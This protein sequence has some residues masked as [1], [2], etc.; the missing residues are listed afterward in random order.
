MYNV[1]E[2]ITNDAL[3]CWKDVGVHCTCRLMAGWNYIMFCRRG[4]RAEQCRVP[5]E[6][7]STWPSLHQHMHSVQRTHNAR[8]SDEVFIELMSSWRCRG[9]P[10]LMHCGLYGGQ[11]WVER[12]RKKNCRWSVVLMFPWQ[13][14]GRDGLPE[15]TLTQTLP[16]PVHTATFNNPPLLCPR[17]HFL[18][19]TKVRLAPRHP[20][21]DFI[22]LSV[23]NHLHSWLFLLSS[24]SYP[25]P[26][27]NI[28]IAYSLS[29]TLP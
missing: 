26:A 1:Y 14:D 13:P 10:Y 6:Q 20:C 4:H 9:T 2:S 28:Y 24:N 11:C 25:K 3:G 18:Q 15:P 29:L 8:W 19:Q 21:S 7:R 12:C 5:S 27:A 17:F 22:P 23:L 16:A